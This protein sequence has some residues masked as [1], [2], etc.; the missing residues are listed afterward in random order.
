[1][2]RNYR[3]IAKSGSQVALIG[4]GKTQGGK[5]RLAEPRFYIND[6]PRIPINYNYKYSPP[7]PYAS[8][9]IEKE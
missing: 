8:F 9:T 5:Y 4:I 3:Q 7:L 2:I 1:M 6:I